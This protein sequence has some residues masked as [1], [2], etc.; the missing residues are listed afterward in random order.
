MGFVR[1]FIFGKADIFIKSE[2]TVFGGDV[3]QVGV[4]LFQLF[5]KAVY[6]REKSF[7]FL[8]IE[9]TVEVHSFD[10]I[11]ELYCF[12]EFEGDGVHRSIWE[13]INEENVGE[14]QRMKPENFREW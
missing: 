1:G 12:E 5:Q 3:F 6:K 8:E 10:V 9:V 13:H 7:F 4:Q 14:F 11:I 2:D